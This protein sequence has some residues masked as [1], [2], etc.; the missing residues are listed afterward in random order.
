VF[1]L[2]FAD[3]RMAKSI[4]V[5][6]LT[7][8]QICELTYLS[9]YRLLK[10]RITAIRRAYGDQ[11]VADSPVSTQMDSDPGISS[12][13]VPKSTPGMNTGTSVKNPPK[14]DSEPTSSSPK[15]V[16][17]AS[18]TIP[19]QPPRR[20][21]LSRWHTVPASIHSQM[22]DH[23]PSLSR[24]FSSSNSKITTRRFTKLGE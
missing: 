4:H 6:F 10:K 22:S 9:D 14:H 2:F 24:M 13:A 17:P 19:E 12:A 1:S 8:S 23:A 16:A 5:G 11:N 15:L 18:G 20:K 7:L 3:T 21:P